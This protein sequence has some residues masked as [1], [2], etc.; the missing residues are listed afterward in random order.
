MVMRKTLQKGFT[1]IE[2]LIVIAIIGLL[3]AVVLIAINPAEMMKRGRDSQRLSDVTN[4]K[5]A[6]DIYVATSFQIPATCVASTLYGCGAAACTDAQRS[7]AGT[8]WVPIILTQNIPTLPV[9]P[10]SGQTITY[11]AA[12][13]GTATANYRLACSP[14]STTFEINTY[15]E[16]TTNTSK[17]SSDGG[18]SAILFETGTDLLLL[19]GSGAAV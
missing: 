10:S 6:I 9:D 13:P 8:G 7:S 16:S 15:L 17:I 5:K 18:N 2:L 11:T 3:A 19:D 12:V 14:A 4:L 1:L